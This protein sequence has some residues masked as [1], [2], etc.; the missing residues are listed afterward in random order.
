MTRENMA[1]IVDTPEAPRVHGARSASRAGSASP[2]PRSG[3]ARRATASTS[4]CSTR[5]SPAGAA[6]RSA[7]AS[8]SSARRSC[9]HGSD[10]MKQEFLPKILRNEVE[11]AVG[12]S[13]PDAGSDAASMKLKATRDGDG[14]RLNGQKT[15]TTSAHFAEWYWV[16]ARTDPELE[17]PRASRCSSCRSTTP[18][19]PSTRS[20]RWATSAPTTCSSTTCSCTTTTWSATSTT[21]SSTSPRR[22]TSSASP[23]SRSRRS[24]SGS[25]CCATTC[26]TETVDGEPLQG[27]PGHPPADR[28]A[29]HRGRG[30]RACSACGSSPQ[31]MKGGAPPTTEASEYKLFA[32]ELSKRLAERVDG[33]RRA[34]ARSC[35]CT[36]RTRR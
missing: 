7:R 24:S 15:W 36:P 34:R 2:G 10:K 6:R 23:C 14:W 35:G 20:G 33:H 32:T 3:A 30:R 18:A 11:F 31:S 26:A 28:P 21:A 22:S 29:R 5:R 19:S 1:Q 4:T 12:Y 25:T 8:A 27:R 16:G 17:A 13:E 9:A